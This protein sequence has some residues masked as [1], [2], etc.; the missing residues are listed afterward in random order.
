ME[1]LVAEVERWDR[2]PKLASLW[3]TSTYAKE[4]KRDTVIETASGKHEL[5]FADEFRILGQMFGRDG[6]VQISLVER[7]EDLPMQKCIMETQVS[8]ND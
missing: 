3:W 8:K 5:L 4:E 6:S 7:R 1:E 2:E